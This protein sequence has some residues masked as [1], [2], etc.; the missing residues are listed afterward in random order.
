M[1]T[2]QQNF[3]YYAHSGSQIMVKLKD[4]K[5]PEHEGVF[6]LVSTKP[7]TYTM[8]LTAYTYRFTRTCNLWCVNISELTDTDF[9]NAYENLLN[10]NEVYDYDGLLE[11]YKEWV[12]ENGGKTDDIVKL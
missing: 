6:A 11:T 4:A 10:P 12:M 1:E 3:E 2:K 7:N 5:I 9:S 8:S